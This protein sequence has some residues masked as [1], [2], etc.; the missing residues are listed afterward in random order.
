MRALN[1]EAARCEKQGWQPEK[2]RVVICMSQAFC[3]MDQ[4]K[5]RLLVVY[6][7]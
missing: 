6:F 2:S 7:D 3:L 5:E 4:E 1:S